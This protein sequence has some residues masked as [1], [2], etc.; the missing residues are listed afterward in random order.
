[1][2]YLEKITCPSL[3]LRGDK[4]P[5]MSKSFVEYFLKSSPATKL[6]VVKDCG[7]SV[8]IDQVEDFCD[9]IIDFVDINK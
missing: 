7:H 4:D 3:L 5:V 9:A 6:I 8:H 2:H 1:M